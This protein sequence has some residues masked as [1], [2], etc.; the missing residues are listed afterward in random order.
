M[1]Q[2]NHPG[3]PA[4][5]GFPGNSPSKGW[6]YV[7]TTYSR[8]GFLGRGL[9]AAGGIAGAST[10]AEFLT[11][12]GS[13]SKGAATSSALPTVSMQ[14]SWIKNVEFAG[15]YIADTKG[16]YKAEGVLANLVAGGPTATIE[17]DVVAGKVLIGI[18]SPDSTSQ[19]VAKGADLKIIATMYQKSPF[20]IMS[21]ATKPINTPSDMIGK[22]IGVQ[23][24]NQSIWTAFLKANNINASKITTVPVQFDPTPLASGQV[25]GWFSFITNEPNL[26]AVKGVKTTTFLLNDFDYP[27]ITNTYFVTGAT[28][29]D[30]TKRDQVVKMLRGD[31]KGWQDNLK[32]PQLGSDLTANKYGKALKL[33]AKEQLLENT[34][35]NK[36][37]QSPDTAAHGLFWMTD[38]KIAETVS[39]ITKGGGTISKDLFTLDILEEVYGGKNTIS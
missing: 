34:A 22:K 3:F 8:R 1:R 23:A 9:L 36:L 4:S 27:S 18:N 17:P 13:S 24:A 20:A 37:I 15:S 30:K 29:N 6:G 26:L 7:S 38:E 21:L 39:T 35:G 11:A 25:D 5:A 10:M 28:L 2:H 19:A 14:L 32:D 16:Y 33:D 12:C 31:I